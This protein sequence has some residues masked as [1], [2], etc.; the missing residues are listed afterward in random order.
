MLRKPESSV[1]K[2]TCEDPLASGYPTAVQL[3]RHSSVK[4][5]GPLL[6]MLCISLRGVKPNY[7][8]GSKFEALR[9]GRQPDFC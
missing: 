2:I 7:S 6:D 4:T 5:I 8:P 1:K 3:S 9:R